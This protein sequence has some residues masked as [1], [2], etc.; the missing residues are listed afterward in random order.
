MRSGRGK[1]KKQARKELP[2]RSGQEGGKGPDQNKGKN[3][4]QIWR[5]GKGAVEQQKWIWWNS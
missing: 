5:E 4:M 3:E 2:W 1:H